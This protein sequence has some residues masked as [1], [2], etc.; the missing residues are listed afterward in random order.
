M[1]SEACVLRV[2]AETKA[3]TQRRNLMAPEPNFP[4]ETQ[5]KPSDIYT[6]EKSKAPSPG[7][8]LKA[9]QTS[10]L[11]RR[12]FVLETKPQTTVQPAKAA[13]PHTERL[14]STWFMS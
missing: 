2:A 4:A 8:A 13:G 5:P 10:S 3:P 7:P 9:G 11:P 6:T 1:T 12:V 14:E